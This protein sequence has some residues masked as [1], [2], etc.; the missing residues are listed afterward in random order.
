MTEE[1]QYN[2]DIEVNSE[3]EYIVPCVIN[4]PSEDDI[5]ID[6]VADVSMFFLFIYLCDIYLTISNFNSVLVR[7]MALLGLFVFGRKVRCYE[8]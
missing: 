6:F 1:I 2:T 4:I 8:T 7:S 5:V 3:A